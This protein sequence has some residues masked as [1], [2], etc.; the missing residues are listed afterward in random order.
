MV[1]I[2]FVSFLDSLNEVSPII[3]R[4]VEVDATC[5]DIYT[6]KGRLNPDLTRSWRSE[7]VKLPSLIRFKEKLLIKIKPKHE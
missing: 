1:Y 7:A 4:L 2:V 6:P 3:E 5:A